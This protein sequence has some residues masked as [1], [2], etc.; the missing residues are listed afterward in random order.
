MDETKIIETAA[1][2][3]VGARITTT[4]LEHRES[5]LWRGF[6]SRFSEIP[7]RF[8]TDFFSVKVYPA[9]Y[10]FSHFDLNAKFDKWATIGVSRFADEYDDF[11]TLTIPAGKYAVFIHRGTPAMASVTFGHIFGTWLPKSGFEI[12]NRP[13]LDVLGESWRPFDENAEEE[14]WVPIRGR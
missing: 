4:L 1:R 3:L 10:S 7:D 5:E 11:E 8:G 14:I 9:E 2:K 13:H 12:D 6:R